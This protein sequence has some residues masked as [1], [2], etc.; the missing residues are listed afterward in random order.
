MRGNNK[1]NVQSNI[2]K[3]GNNPITNRA[4]N[5]QT[6]VNPEIDAN[7]VKTNIKNGAVSRAN[8]KRTQ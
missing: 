4:K 2:T 6:A 8:F 3:T 5:E 7:R 1:P